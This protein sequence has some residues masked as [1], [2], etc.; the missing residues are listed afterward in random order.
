M[1]RLFALSQ[2]GFEMV[3]PIALGWYLDEWLDW[4]PWGVVGGAVL[5]LVGGLAH[6]LLLL[7]RIEAKDSSS[8]QDRQ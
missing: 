2:I 3:A 5:G 1:G 4:K 6:I 8:R 7:K